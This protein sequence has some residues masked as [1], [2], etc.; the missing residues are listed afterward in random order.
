MKTTEKTEPKPR[1]YTFELDDTDTLDFYDKCISDGTTP[2][3]VLS[4][5]VRDLVYSN[6][7]NGSDETLFANQYYDRVG[8][9]YLNDNPTFLQWLMN[10]FSVFDAQILIEDIEECEA[11]IEYCRTE[12]EELEKPGNEEHIAVFEREL[13]KDR[14][15]LNELYKDYT[16]HVEKPEEFKAGIEGVKKYTEISEKIRRGE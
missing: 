12:P 5:F 8:Y 2:E 1:T 7:S 10:H 9:R 15:E 4:G 11:E 6:R 14:Q 13:E 16:E 3:E